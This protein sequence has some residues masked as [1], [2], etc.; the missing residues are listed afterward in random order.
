MMPIY[1]S[2][3]AHTFVSLT[4]Y[5]NF[6]F[7]LYLRLQTWFGEYGSIRD[8]LA[9]AFYWYSQNLPTVALLLPR[10]GLCLALLLAFST[11]P[12]DSLSSTIIRNRDPTYFR[13]NQGTLTGYA[14]GVLIANASWAAWRI[15]VLLVSLI[16]LWVISGQGCAGICGPRFRWE[17]EDNDKTRSSTYG[18]NNNSNRDI[19]A[20]A[21]TWKE[22][23]RLR[24]QDTYE[25]CSTNAP[26]L[27]WGNSSFPSPG[28]T[29]EKGKQVIEHDRI[30]VPNVLMP[31]GIPSAPAPAR[32]RALAD[33][34]FE[35]PEDDKEIEFRHRE[36]DRGIGPSTRQYPFGRQGSAQVS[37]QDRVPFPP[38]PSKSKQTISR[39]AT[40]QT[41]SE[42]TSSS[43]SIEN[44]SG[45]DDEESGDKFDESEERST[46]HASNS[47]SSLGY[48]ISPSRRYLFGFR[49]PGGRGNS[50]S[51]RSHQ[52]RPSQ[53]GVSQFGVSHSGISQSTGN[54]PS[55]KSSSDNTS[56]NSDSGPSASPG[57][58]SGGSSIPMPP[59]HPNPQIRIRAPS[60]PLAASAEPP[61]VRS[62]V[63]N[64]NLPG[65]TLVGTELMQ[66]DAESISSSDSVNGERQDEVRLLNPGASNIDLAI[67]CLVMGS[68]S[69]SLR[70]RTG[71]STRS[72]ANSS[73][74]SRSSIPAVR[75]R[76]SSLGVAVRSQARTM[77][78]SVSATSLGLVAGTRSRA[79]SSM[80]R[81]EE[82][83]AIHQLPT[84]PSTVRTRDVS[85]SNQESSHSDAHSFSDPRAWEDDN[86]MTSSHSRSQSGSGGE[87]WTFGQP[88]SFMLPPTSHLRE[89]VH[90]DDNDQGGL[91]GS[92]EEEIKTRRDDP[93]REITR[94]FGPARIHPQALVGPAV[95]GAIPISTSVA[96]APVM[97]DVFHSTRTSGVTLP[98]QIPKVNVLHQVHTLTE[99]INTEVGSS[100]GGTG[101]SLIWPDISTA[102]QSFVTAPLTMEGTM[103]TEEGSG[104][105]RRTERRSLD[106][107]SW[108]VTMS[109]AMRGA[110]IANVGIG[111]GGIGPERT[112]TM[113]D[114]RQR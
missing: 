106:E 96:S 93:V 84:M 45:D 79:N 54:Q 77:F 17:E 19:D 55:T 36:S 58:S 41:S 113:G 67:S 13:E 60:V 39:S 108:S 15:L 7:L 105:G 98:L 104:E 111:P 99:N 52:S 9:E 28:W 70:T 65:I 78:R 11:S 47:M 109:R 49:Y 81:L 102:A 32:H 103:T 107:A 42:P 76:V 89:D 8:G 18:T 21:W 59:R 30:D 57:Q 94:D 80:T 88:M 34:F 5:T 50:T 112:D 110:G 73:I 87:N 97:E 23:T 14:R 56:T 64:G 25:L 72:R 48:P 69:A 68:G 3:P 100:L 37:S 43:G 66:G 114:W 31:V 24:I 86:Y 10:A 44:D 40:S 33:D 51:S 71:S 53:S 90:S 83:E 29:K 91:P 63:D 6:R 27:R 35:S 95:P 4:S 26:G 20:L 74:R 2:S 85:G 61:G 16:G 62:K 1:L 22:R 92:T 12:V 82:E 46:G 75:S 101:S 38:S